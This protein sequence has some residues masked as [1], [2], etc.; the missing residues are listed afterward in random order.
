MMHDGWRM[1]HESIA[2]WQTANT[3]SNRP[4]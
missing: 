2:S 4:V 3:R 1:V